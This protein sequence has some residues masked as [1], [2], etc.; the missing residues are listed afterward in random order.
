ME[1]NI[2]LMESTMN[3]LKKVDDSIIKKMITN[4]ITGKP[5][6]NAIILEGVFAILEGVNNNNREYDI[7][8]Y[9][10][11]IAILKTKI[12]SKKGLY[13]EYEHPE[14]YSINSNNLSHKILDIW[15]I[16][17]T[18]TVMGRIMLL[19]QGKGLLARE[20]IESG[21]QLAISAR[22][23]GKETKGPN[24]VFS[25]K[26]ELLVTY[27]LVYHPGFE[28]AV[29]DYITLDNLNESMQR[30]QPSYIANTLGYS[31][32][33][34][35]SALPAL[36]GM[37]KKFLQDSNASTSFLKWCESNGLQ[38]INES[39]AATNQKKIEEKKMQD[40]DKHH[41]ENIQNELQKSVQKNLAENQQQFFQELQKNQNILKH[42]NKRRSV[43]GKSYYDNS[44]GFIKDG[45]EVGL[46]LSEDES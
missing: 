1:Q 15:Y 43:Q 40:G 10:K 8:S 13:G 46:A 24:G 9:L 44:A 23:G 30:R 28:N 17:E 35:E 11:W 3:P 25:S 36:D 12:F 4:P 18:K 33:L 29:L 27:D 34:Y 32:K 41:K 6:K 14:G 38:Q 7:E 19:N 21:G 2:I 22:A 20:V 26:I 16:P 42:R 39:S 45:A 31:I 37:Y 5:Y